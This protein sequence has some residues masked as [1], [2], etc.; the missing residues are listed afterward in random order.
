[1]TDTQTLRSLAAHY[2]LPVGALMRH[3]ELEVAH[4]DPDDPLTA[5]VE[6]LFRLEMDVNDGRQLLLRWLQPS[7]RARSRCWTSEVVDNCSRPGL[8]M[9]GRGTEIDGAASHS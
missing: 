3:L 4:H 9:S 2:N 1:M 7:A 6:R 5:T 8:P